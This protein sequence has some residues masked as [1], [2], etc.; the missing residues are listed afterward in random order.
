MRI[1]PTYVSI[2]VTVVSVSINALRREGPRMLPR[3][4]RKRLALHASARCA[5][6]L[7]TYAPI[8]YDPPRTATNGEDLLPLPR[9]QTGLMLGEFPFARVGTGSRSLV[10]FPGIMDALQDV[11][12][13]PRFIA[14]FCQAMT[15]SH[16]VFWI[17]RRR[18]LPHDHSTR[19]MARDYARL[20][21]EELGPCDVLGV[22]MG[23]AIAQDFAADFPQHV[24][25]LVLAMCGPRMEPEK[26][27]LCRN[28]I[29]LAQGARWRDLYL[30]MIARTYRP[31]R[32]AVYQALMPTVDSVF[33][34]SPTIGSDFVVS[35]QACLDFD[36]SERLPLIKARTLVLGGA[37]DVLMPAEGIREVADR[38][39]GASLH[40]FEGSGHGAFEE[41]KEEF[42]RVISEFLTG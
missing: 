35:G 40:L 11:T 28:W 31:A 5:H 18:G 4:F 26:K 19:D 7:A 20:F 10:V 27:E 25:R 13:N 24:D 6:E 41:C 23:S 39:P 38:I 36:T 21:A 1:V 22:S 29:T 30:D 17:G 34:E 42:D 33:S 2:G 3:R 14:W 15:F 16:T 12:G 37:E 8:R 9:A 32:R